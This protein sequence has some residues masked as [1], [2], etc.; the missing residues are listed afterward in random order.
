MLE[1]G[2][3]G[4]PYEDFGGLPPKA[5]PPLSQ[6]AQPEPERNRHIVCAQL[7]HADREERVAA[8]V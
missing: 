4:K 7:G 5:L 6:F 3:R 8:L 2:L 1:I